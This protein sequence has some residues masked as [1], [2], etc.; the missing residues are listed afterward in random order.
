MR[1]GASGGRLRVRATAGRGHPRRSP[2]PSPICP[3]TETGPPSP[4]RFARLPW[5]PRTWPPTPGRCG[6]CQGGAAAELLAG[7]VTVTAASF[8][9]SI[10]LFLLGS[11]S[12][13]R[14]PFI[15]DCHEGTRWTCPPWKPLS[16]ECC[17][18]RR[19]RK[20]A[21][22][23]RQQH[24]HRRLTA[25]STS[26]SLTNVRVVPRG[27][28]VGAAATHCHLPRIDRACGLRWR[29]RSKAVS[30]G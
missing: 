18:L 25:F 2:S 12:L 26:Y 13:S 20:T 1:P 5:P 10:R 30:R 8:I 3:R 28:Y 27:L 14:C 19:M 21:R 24:A 7:P 29:R 22:A 9:G 16:T 17:L 6:P 11:E 4:G 15:G 23:S